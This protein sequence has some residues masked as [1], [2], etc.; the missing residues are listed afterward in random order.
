MQERKEIL[1]M[2]S[3]LAGGGAEKV[4]ALLSKGLSSYYDVYI[5]LNKKKI[6]YE[7]DGNLC[8]FELNSPRNIINRLFNLSKRYFGLR[9]IK[10]DLKRL[11]ASISFTEN[12]NAVNILTHRRNQKTIVTVHSTISL[13]NKLRQKY[14]IITKLYNLPGITVVAVSQGVKKDLI[15]NFGVFPRKI[16]VIY[17]PISISDIRRK[18]NENLG[19]YEQIF[20]Y[21]TFINVGRLVYQKAQWHLLRIFKE[22]KRSFPNFKLILIGE[23]KLKGLLVNLAEELGLKT[24][25]QNGDNFSPEYDVFFLGF[26]K[27]PYKFI[28]NSRLFIS[29]SIHEG[30]PMVLLESLACGTAVVHSDCK[31][32]P[33]EILAPDMS[34]HESVNKP[35]LAKYGILMPLLNG[36]ILSSNDPLTE[37]EEIWVSFIA[38]LLKNEKI[39]LE[40]KEKAYYRAR[41]FDINV[42]AKKWINLIED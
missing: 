42:I 16:K 38:E 5:C 32:G 39:I 27:N 13:F 14:K 8:S 35:L 4:A 26:Q 6:V 11:S 10:K 3:T 2:V 23:G 41:D 28:R 17:N 40:Y 30:F 18:S 34:I 22:L 20:S 1:L 29:T 25:L 12:T 36:K 15:E 37:G 7:Y 19:K 9:K 21:P 31:S 24:Y 33:R